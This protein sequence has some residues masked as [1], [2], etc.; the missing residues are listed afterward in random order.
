MSELK[1][2]CLV[3]DDEQHSIEVLASHISDTPYLNLVCATTNQQEALKTLANEAIDLI[4]LDVQMPG[5]TG[6]EFIKIL[7]GN[8][9]IVFCSAHMQYAVDGFENDV[10]DFLLKPVTYSRFLKTAQKGLRLVKEAH[11]M[12]VQER[13]TPEYIFVKN[14]V[15]GKVVRVNF[16]ELL[17]VE[18]QKNYVIFHQRQN[19]VITYM[20]ITDAAARLP[21]KEFLRVHR[22]FIV[23]LDRIHTV[24]GNLIRL[25]DTEATVT[26]GENY[27]Q[28][29]YDF[30]HIG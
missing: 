17:Y 21:A 14:G 2:N 22:S 10:V 13:D 6:L 3:L 30:L 29:L 28:P 27:K 8:Y 1:I 26:I 11:E 9:H 20:S 5:L 4:F 12:V 18:A 16:R 25:T 7:Q 19:K 24:E 23:R 15:K